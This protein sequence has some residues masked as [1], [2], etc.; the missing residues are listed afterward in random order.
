MEVHVNGIYQM[1]TLV[2][3]AK[4]TTLLNMI[5]IHLETAITNAANVYGSLRWPYVLPSIGHKNKVGSMRKSVKVIQISDWRRLH[6]IEKFYYAV[7][8]GI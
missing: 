5:T 2:L 4:V 7:D 1:P 3:I 6:A 8:I